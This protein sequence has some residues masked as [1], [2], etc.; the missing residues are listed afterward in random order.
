MTTIAW[1]GEY[2]AA[3]QGAWVGGHIDRHIKV[4]KF[5]VDGSQVLYACVGVSGFANR[6]MHHIQQPDTY[7]L[8]DWRNWGLPEGSA[9]VGIMVFPFGVLY[10]IDAMG[11]RIKM[12][13]HGT[14][15]V[16]AAGAGR[17]MALGAL[18]VGASAQRAVEI[19]IEYSD[20]GG[21][22]VTVLKHD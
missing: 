21:H 15:N 11:T 12:E 3:D 14:R 5:M 19:A 9:T 16:F 17:E 2:L 22:G 6:M 10:E 13:G 20:Y 8:P 7:P 4:H 18:L 1:D